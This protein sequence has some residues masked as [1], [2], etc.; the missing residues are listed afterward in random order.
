MKE[1]EPFLGNR[2]ASSGEFNRR[3]GWC[4]LLTAFAVGIYLDPW[5]LSERDAVVWIRS[6][7]MYARH[8]Q[9]VLFGMGFLNIAV[10]NILRR[11]PALPQTGWIVS[12][13]AGGTLLYCGSYLAGIVW[14][15]AHWIVPL[16]ALANLTGFTMWFVSLHRTSAPFLFRAVLVVF[17][18][19][20]LVDAGMGF[21]TAAPLSLPWGS[22]G[23][24][25]GVRLR[26]VRLARAAA[27]ALSLLT[28]LYDELLKTSDRKWRWGLRLLLFGAV[29][30]PCIL[31]S[32]AVIVL[33]LKYLLGLPAQAALLGVIA[34]VV[35]A[36][37]R[38]S[39]SEASGWLLVTISMMAG[40]VMGL[41]AF[42][43]PFKSP[44][45]LGEYNDW[46]RRFARLGHAYL[47]VLGLICILLSR[48]VWE[49]SAL[50]HRGCPSVLVRTGMGLFGAATLIVPVLIW[51]VPASNLPTI[52]L[53]PGPALA[54]FGIALCL[55]P[56]SESRSQTAG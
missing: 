3:L 43:G 1:G 45:F 11:T 49:A 26:M 28:L 39:L 32:A 21:L 46:N 36:V 14:P 56:Q 7:K 51:T 44:E 30:M 22:L 31:V 8:A 20:M 6:P 55:W 13:V 33:P 12:L 23:E 50:A 16:G 18:F 24:I 29:S 53:A 25:D 17:C 19:G 41:Y 10:A 37:K 35:L 15:R 54:T 42:E 40:L 34:G 48:Q 27:I 5:S 52:F 4:L 47:I 2:L 38:S 9:A